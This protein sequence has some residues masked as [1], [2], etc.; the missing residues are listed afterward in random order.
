MTYGPMWSDPMWSVSWAL[1]PA[2][3]H[4]EQVDPSA[5]SSI[6]PLDDKSSSSIKVHYLI[7]T[8]SLKFMMTEA[9]AKFKEYNDEDHAQH[10]LIEKVI[11]RLLKEK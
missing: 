3:V 11:L 1:S 4:L 6:P 5:G 2:S 10:F 7:D 9:C 8:Y